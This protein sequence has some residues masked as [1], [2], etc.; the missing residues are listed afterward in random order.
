[1]N[2]N[3]VARVLPIA[4][5]AFAAGCSILSPRPDRARF[6]LLTADAAPARIASPAALALGLGPIKLPGYLDQA[7]VVTRVAPNR[8]ELSP[9]DRWAESLDA[10]VR[11]VLAHELASRL[12]NAQIVN[13]PWYPTVRV[14]YQIEVDFERFERAGADSTE[15]AARWT[16]RDGQSRQI[17]MTRDARFA[18]A[19]ANGSMEAAAAALSADLEDL[20]NQIAT[21]IAQLNQPPAAG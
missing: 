19:A 17:L 1:M 21:A 6:Y 15:L 2:R 18:A 16:I 8:I 20:A 13:F 9:A 10:N 3:R 11:D 4:I 5:A 12:P 7:Q 14:R